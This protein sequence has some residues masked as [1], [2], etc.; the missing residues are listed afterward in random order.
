[1]YKASLSVWRAERYLLYSLSKEQEWE[2]PTHEHLLQLFKN[3]FFKTF[4][5]QITKLISGCNVDK[6]NFSREQVLAKPM[7][8][9]SIML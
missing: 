3:N 4:D 2:S 7:I 6:L 9:D 5:K 8:L 1:M